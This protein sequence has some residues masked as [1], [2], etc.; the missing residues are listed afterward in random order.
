VLY[1]NK[2]VSTVAMTTNGSVKFNDDFVEQLKQFQKIWLCVSVDGILEHGEYVRHGSQWPTVHNTIVKLS[3]LENCNFQL[4]TV[5]QFYS[6]LTFPR[7]VD[8][9]IA[10]DLDINLL[11]CDTP[12]FLSIHS[13]LPGHHAKFLQFIIPT[14]II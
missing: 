6:S 13:M 7:I 9:A 10:N 14:F 2:K 12:D 5:L 4:S 3:K 1:E 11:F 8:Y